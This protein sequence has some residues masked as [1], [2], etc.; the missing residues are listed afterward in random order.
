MVSIGLLLSCMYVVYVTT[1]CACCAEYYADDSK[2]PV[3]VAASASMFVGQ[4]CPGMHFANQQ[5]LYE[6]ERNKSV[7]WTWEWLTAHLQRKAKF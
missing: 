4:K 6:M 7:A 2:K 5:L 3:A 1:T